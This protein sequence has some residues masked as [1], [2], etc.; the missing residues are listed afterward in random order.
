MP[1]L[2]KTLP[3]ICVA[4]GFPTASQLAR[5]ADREYKDGNTFL[6][7]RL[8]YLPDPAAGVEVIR[9]LRKSLPDA[10]ILATCRHKRASGHFRGDVKQQVAILE[11]AAVA[12]AALIDLE[13]E[14]AESAKSTVA[15]LA[16]AAPL[17]ISYHNFENTS[18]LEPVLRRLERVPASVYKIVTTARKPSDNL[19]LLQFARAHHRTPLVVFA[20]SEIGLPTR[21]L[22]PSLGGLYTFAAPGESGGTAPGQVPAKLMRSLYRSE[23]LTRHSRLYGVVACPVAHS[24]SPLIHNRAFQAR[25]FDAVY[26]PF[27]V[28]P[29]HFPDWMKFATAYPVSG[30]SVTIPHKQ[31]ILRH[32]DFVEP[33][34]R[35]IGAVNTVWRKAGKWRGTNTDT[36]GVIKPLSRH[37]RIA[38]SSVLI[39][40]YG[41]AAR[42]AAIA[43]TDASASVTITGRNMKIAQT[44]ARAVRGEAVT[45]KEAA[46]N[47]YDAL[48]HAT[49]V[50]MSPHTSACLFADRLP[51]GIVFDMVYNPH[52]TLLLKRARQQG[53]V[54][55]PG[56][57]ML[58]EQAAHQFEIWTGESAPRLVMRN[59]LEAS[60]MCA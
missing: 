33:Q 37:L 8:D 53:C 12:G 9:K 2:P 60:I 23:K 25:R 21:V 6:E 46:D 13:I 14:S 15:T 32:L 18:A 26:L 47:S 38:H 48:V 42:A 54:T 7:F 59:A 34:A 4:L 22:T 58:L 56:I 5:A 20:M 11:S 1:S 41:G 43:L 24:K 51:A 28:A 40:G 55:I 49:P 57:E 52:E 44:L 3:H 10:H 19:R 16:E 29:A 36:E 39:A 45:L 27:L 50:G 35:R 30:F 17:C 31:R